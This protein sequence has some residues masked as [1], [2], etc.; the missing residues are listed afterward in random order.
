MGRSIQNLADEQINAICY[1]Q[2]NAFN[3]AKAPGVCVGLDAA[4]IAALTAHVMPKLLA[5]RYF[6]TDGSPEDF[7]LSVRLAAV[8]KIYGRLHER[9]LPRRQG[10][11][12]LSWVKIAQ[13]E[14]ARITTSNLEAVID[15][16]NLVLKAERFDLLDEIFREARI[17]QMPVEAIIAFLRVP[18]MARFR[19]KEWR[20]FRRRARAE[21]QARGIDADRVLKGMS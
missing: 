21:L 14:P 8:P 17:G 13:S 3:T 19:L 11:I 16:L 15:G 10:S 20:G 12:E 4:H 2:T 5:R 1:A 18:F 6:S 7:G 9:V